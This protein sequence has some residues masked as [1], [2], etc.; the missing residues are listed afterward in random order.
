MGFQDYCVATQDWVNVSKLSAKLCLAQST[1]SLFL[2][3]HKD[4][5]ERKPGKGPEVFVRCRLI[6]RKA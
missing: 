3:R 2:L 6:W 4:F 1:V 5:F